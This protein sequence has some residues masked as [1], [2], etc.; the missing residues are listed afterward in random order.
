[1]DWYR[2]MQGSLLSFVSSKVEIA[3]VSAQF[4]S[5]ERT[6][7]TTWRKPSRRRTEKKSRNGCGVNI[8]I[9]V[10]PGIMTYCQ[11]IF[12]AQIECGA[13]CNTWGQWW[14]PRV[15]QTMSQIGISIFPWWSCDLTKQFQLKWFRK[16]SNAACDENASR[17][18]NDMTVIGHGLAEPDTLGPLWQTLQACLEVSKH[19]FSIHGNLSRVKSTCCSFIARHCMLHWKMIV[20]ASAVNKCPCINW[21]RYSRLTRLPRHD[22]GPVPGDSIPGW[23]SMHGP[24]TGIVPLRDEIAWAGGELQN[25]YQPLFQKLFESLFHTSG[26]AHQISARLSWVSPWSKPIPYFIPQRDW[27]IIFFEMPQG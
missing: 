20:Q 16:S 1:M 8:L 27:F 11:C 17:C 7:V 14:P 24:E 3:F 10:C 15:N 5:R 25:S 2:T 26:L 4:D 6:W 18:P 9:W 19:R 12:V 23:L 13:S 21:V 22:R